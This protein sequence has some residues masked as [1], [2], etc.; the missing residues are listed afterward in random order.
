MT[1]AHVN[2]KTFPVFIEK[3][4]DGWY[5][6]S[7]PIFRGCYTKGKTLDEALAN[8]RD[9][10]AL[11]LAESENQRIARSYKPLETSLHTVALA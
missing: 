2:R 10:I 6:A 4:H 3:G 11:C 7:V 1:V 8:I 9:A 5:L